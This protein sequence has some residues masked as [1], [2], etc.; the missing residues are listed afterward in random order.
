MWDIGSYLG[1]LLSFILL[2]LDWSFDTLII[3]QEL[4]KSNMAPQGLLIQL[5]ASKFKLLQKNI[6][7][8]ATFLLHS[9]VLICFYRFCCLCFI[10]LSSVLMKVCTFDWK[11][12]DRNR[13]LEI[14]INW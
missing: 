3:G 4:P 2:L 13:F 1:D 14:R 9:A 10:N 12:R 6:V 7:V 11:F 5:L 8:L